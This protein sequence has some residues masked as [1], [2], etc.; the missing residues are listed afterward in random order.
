MIGSNTRDSASAEWVLLKPPTAVAVATVATQIITRAT[1]GWVIS[2][3][4]AVVAQTSNFDVAS[5][6][7]CGPKPKT[8]QDHYSEP[9]SFLGR[10]HTLVSCGGMQEACRIHNYIACEARRQVP[11][12]SQFSSHMFTPRPAR[13][14][15]AKKRSAFRSRSVNY[16]CMETLVSA[17]LVLGVA[18]AS[19]QPISYVV[20]HTQPRAALIGAETSHRAPVPD[21]ASWSLVRR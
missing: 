6:G 13:K 12:S 8:N 3:S 11:C 5:T 19:A 7:T 10:V 2:D 1:V 14:V 16:C 15:E 4:P 9:C 17:V 18:F 21:R 20:T